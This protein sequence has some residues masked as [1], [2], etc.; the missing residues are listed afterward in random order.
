[1]SIQ[2]NPDDYRKDAFFISN[3]CNKLNEIHLH[4]GDDTPL[5]SREVD[6]ND[7]LSQPLDERS[8]NLYDRMVT[9]NAEAMLK[10]SKPWTRDANYFQHVHVSSLA[11]MKMTLHAQSGGSIEIM[12]MLT[13]KIVR[14][15]IVV[16][17]VYPLP[18]EG[19][20]TRV[21]AQA[22]GYEFMVQYLDSL[23]SSGRYE[24]IVGWYHSHPGYGCWLSGIDVGTQSLN[25]QFQ[26]PYLAIVVD[27]MRTLTDGKVEI[28]AFRTYTEEYIK[29]NMGSNATGPTN[30]T[31][32]NTASNITTTIATGNS[33]ITRAG[34]TGSCTNS[35][36][37]GSSLFGSNDKAKK[38]DIIASSHIPQEK[39]KDF[40]M[41]SSKYYSLS[42][43]V[44]RSNIDHM[45]LSNL[46]NK[47]WISQVV[48]PI[49]L[50]EQRSRLL[51][52]VDT[53]LETLEKRSALL[54]KPTSRFDLAPSTRN[55]IQV[56]L[57]ALQRRHVPMPQGITSLRELA[58][59]MN[60]SPS[61]LFGSQLSP[62]SRAN[63][64]SKMKEKEMDTDDSDTDM[65]DDVDPSVDSDSESRMDDESVTSPNKV[66]SSTQPNE[67]PAPHTR[68]SA[69][70]G[71]G[72]QQITQDLEN[73]RKREV[74]TA[75]M[76]TSAEASRM[77]LNLKLQK[78]VFLNE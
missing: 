77:L 25:Q 33:A 56:E 40:G 12:G 15:G 75:I 71:Y 11:L 2:T 9:D 14:N 23:R 19:T 72:Q 29:A 26:D 65:R 62:F 57:A 67:G 22:E 54:K 30:T 50:Q 46:W 28:G 47:F 16:M 41:H 66:S 5:D 43:H 18:V 31:T 44:F 52:F 37:T 60:S 32:T 20:E 49:D 63:L 78:M 42:I 55:P 34:T 51:E 17:D 53:R 64:L 48:G 39:A 3:F 36:F 68:T 38:K 27:P 74:N 61:Q 76:A 1:M 21:N 58:Q 70:V 7:L 10:S 13:G 73:I 59:T 24:N 6:M 35:S 8:R 69:S 45:I 4:R